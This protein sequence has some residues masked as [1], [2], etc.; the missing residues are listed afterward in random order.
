MS[1]GVDSSL[2][3]Q[4]MQ[5]L[6]YDCIG[7]TMR[8]FENEDAG[9]PREKTCCSLDDVEDARRVAYRLGMPFY[10]FNFTDAFRD[11]VIRDFVEEY[12]RGRTPNPCI[13]CNRCMKFARLYD[14][15]RELGC[16]VVVTGHYARIVQEDGKYLLKKGLDASKDQSYVLYFLSQEHLAH[17]AFPIGELRKEDVRA[18]AA[19]AGF[20]N[21]EKP[22]SQD[23]CFVPDGDYARVIAQH[24][25]V[26][27][28][29]KFVDTNGKVLGEHKGIT[30]YTLGQRR[31]L[32][33]P[34]ADR[35]YVVA[36]RPED[37]TVVLG[38]NDDLFSR[39]AT[40]KA[41]HWIS[42]T[43]P[44]APFRG[45]AKIRYRHA[46]QPATVTP[47]GGAVRIVFDEPQRA[48]T[49]GQSAV[50]YDGDTVLGGGIIE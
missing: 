4:R 38:S 36:I 27:A 49:P 18:M 3:A 29:G 7:C 13:V 2:A 31:G 47:D 24:G 19:T 14:R 39:D 41:F 20:A 42:G 16:D 10:V 37:N 28:P 12:E 46:E 5:Q 48:I 11:T 44:T 26:S 6:G 40:V 1:G 33:I 25:G 8:L 34:A 23:I 45:K 21:A 30:H 50:L 35:L 17:T 32:G 15:A 22:D 9:L 43:A